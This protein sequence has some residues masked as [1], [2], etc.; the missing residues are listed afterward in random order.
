MVTVEYDDEVASNCNVPDIR[1]NV[2]AY[3]QQAQEDGEL[4]NGETSSVKE[5]SVETVSIQPTAYQY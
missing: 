5:Y 1:D 4:F 2:A 3:L